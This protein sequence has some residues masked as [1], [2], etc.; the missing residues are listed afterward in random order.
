[1][2]TMPPAI[3]SRDRPAV[4]DDPPSRAARADDERSGPGSPARPLAT[5]SGLD[6]SLYWIFPSS[7]LAMLRRDREVAVL[8]DDFLALASTGSASTNSRASGS[9]GLPG[10][11]FT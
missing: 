1:M 11:R 3:T 8:D 2:M 10:A 4:E 5:V 7:S 9:S 6:G